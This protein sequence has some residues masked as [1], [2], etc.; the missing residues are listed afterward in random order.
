MTAI[1]Y[2]VLIGL[3]M[4]GL[5]CEPKLVIPTVPKIDP[6]NDQYLFSSDTSIKPGTI[7]GRDSN[8][9]TFRV[10]PTCDTAIDESYDLVDITSK[11]ILDFTSEKSWQGSLGG[12]YQAVS[13][14]LNM[15]SSKF[16]TISASVSSGK[17]LQI[18]KNTI[19]KFLYCCSLN[20]SHCKEFGNEYVA[21]V[22]DVIVKAKEYESLGA[23]AKV[24][25]S[26][27][28]IASGAGTFK[29]SSRQEQTAT[30]KYFRFKILPRS[31]SA[32]S[33]PTRHKARCC[34]CPIT[35]HL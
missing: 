9:Y 20:N 5:G 10:S 27:S 26:T 17:R 12:T 11:H 4:F 16:Y 33:G 7:V 22:G 6:L 25:E 2:L 23:D 30:L 24:S 19:D 31:A 15:D 8:E 32:C 34:S 18:R 14:A 13:G 3:A 35:Y 21:E 28:Y 1:R 29:R